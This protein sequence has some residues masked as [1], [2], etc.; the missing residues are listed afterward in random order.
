MN[1]DDLCKKNSRLYGLVG[2]A[3]GEQPFVS[4]VI[5]ARNEERYLA[6]C[7]DSLLRQ[8]YPADRF[9]VLVVENG[10]TDGTAAV[11]LAYAKRD[12]RIHLMASFGASHQA[13]A[14]NAGVQSARGSIIA[15]VDAHG[16]VA[17]DYIERVTAAFQRHPEAVAVGGP[18]LPLGSQLLERVVGIARSSRLGVGGGWGT[19]RLIQ[20]HCVRTVGCP[21]YRRDAL[22]AIGLF[23]VTMRY[24][25]DDE[26]NWRLAKS[27]GKIYTSPDVRQFNRPRGSLRALAYQYWNYGRGR[28]RLL[29]KHPDFV[30]PKHLVPVALVLAFTLLGVAAFAHPFARTAFGVLATAYGL[31]ILAAF[32]GAIRHGWREAMLVPVA[33]ATMHWTYGTGMLWAF[34]SYMV[35]RFRQERQY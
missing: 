13:G 23:D 34:S 29:L 11:A 3:L 8:T 9:E 19:D 21:A 18:Y 2:T 6:A 1:R 35:S 10:S 16:T 7:L 14:M 26:L 22:L 30:Q 33:I 31:V 5:P 17:E 20:D 27:A 24:A 15:R 4:V 12:E 25:E 28:L 32:A